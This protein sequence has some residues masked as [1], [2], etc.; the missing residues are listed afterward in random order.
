MALRR[1]RVRR[2]GSVGAGLYGFTGYPPERPWPQSPGQWIDLA[3]EAIKLF[4]LEFDPV[5]DAPIP[6]QLQVARFLAPVAALITVI[7]ST[8]GLVGRAVKSWWRF[9]NT[10]LVIVVGTSRKA[11]TVAKAIGATGARVHRVDA[12]DRALRRRAALK[13]AA[14]VYLCED[15]SRGDSGAENVETAKD[16][17]KRRR[18][19]AGK[20]YAHVSDLG[21]AWKL[22]VESLKGEDPS[23]IEYFNLDE[24]AARAYLE[25]EQLDHR[26][27]NVRIVVV[28]ATSMAEAIVVAS[29]RKVRAELGFDARLTVTLIDPLASKAAEAYRARW[30]VVKK[31]CHIEAIDSSLHAYLGRPE[32]VEPAYRIYICHND[33]V[34]ALSSAMAADAAWR[35]RPGPVVVLLGQFAS[36][37][38]A[39]DSRTVV[40]GSGSLVIY[41]TESLAAPLVAA[42]TVGLA[43]DLAVAAHRAFLADQLQQGEQM[44]SSA[45]MQ[46]WEELSEDLK[47]ANYAQARDLIR[48]LRLIGATIDLKEEGRPPFRV[49]PDEVERLAPLEHQRW[50]AERKAEGW[51]R[52]PRDDTK[53]RHPDLVPWRKLSKESQDKNRRIIRNLETAYDP[54]LG[55]LGLQIVR[56]TELGSTSAHAHV[57]AAADR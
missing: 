57:V 2:S 26:L 16:V 56:N 54:A 3:Y 29:A 10:R 52:G 15:W 28:G 45:S 33:E 25:A 44:G 38:V 24:L 47:R 32:A 13:R 36:S 22:R 41:G 12:D 23:G 30:D 35:D 43:H 17:V 6:W 34:A 27:S 42:G 11:E 46:P 20:V 48:K 9:R 53:K 49:T 14:A 51:R 50:V 1:S 21:T 39:L 8:S 4:G 7:I 18:A 31:M 40:H 19:L 5:G 55:E 37:A